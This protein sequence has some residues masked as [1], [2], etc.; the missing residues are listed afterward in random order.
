MPRPLNKLEQIQKNFEERSF[1]KEPFNLKVDYAKEAVQMQDEIEYLLTLIDAI[2][3]LAHVE[4]R[5]KVRK[6]KT[7]GKA[8]CSRS[9]CA[10]ET[11]TKKR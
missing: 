9:T 11:K 5:Q 10:W 2:E 4:I 7:K 6:D 1:L 3:E 8:S